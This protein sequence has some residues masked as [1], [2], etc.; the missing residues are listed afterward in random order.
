MSATGTRQNI[1]AF[2]LD[3]NSFL[4]TFKN[5]SIDF[6]NELVK[7]AQGANTVAKQCI[8]KMDSTF[9][10]EVEVEDGTC[11][12]TSLSVSKL[13]IL[14]EDRKYDFDTFDITCNVTSE[15]TDGGAEVS[16]FRQAYERAYS[17]T[18]RLF[19]RFADTPFKDFDNFGS[20]DPTDWNTTLDIDL[21]TTSGI[22]MPVVIRSGKVNIDNILTSEFAFEGKAEPES[23]TDVDTTL[24]GV[25]FAGDALIDVV[26][27]VT[28]GSDSLTFEATCLVSSL[29][30]N[31]ANGQITSISGSANAQGPWTITREDGSG[32]GG[33][34]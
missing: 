18:V 26:M 17:G 29:S 24:V 8:V 34:A 19:D 10:F 21:G 31:V 6:L 16:R 2:T 30:I 22:K 20:P 9:D 1:S 23:P 4:G 27:T 25:V 13:T 14:G 32:G 28:Y 7:A 5:M 12:D 15:T 11:R 33:G 3:S